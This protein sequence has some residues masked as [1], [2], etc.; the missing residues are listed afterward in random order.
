M[1]HIHQLSP[2]GCKSLLKQLGLSTQGTNKERCER[3]L[4]LSY[5]KKYNPNNKLEGPKT[6]TDIKKS[7]PNKKKKTKS[8]QDIISQ[9]MQQGN[10]VV[11]IESNTMVD[12]KKSRKE[13]NK[14]KNRMLDVNVLESTTCEKI[15]EL[16]EETSKMNI[17]DDYD[18]WSDFDAHSITFHA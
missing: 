5:S 14:E 16:N 2:D 7:K 11:S 4:H 12:R 18:D 9:L 6:L 15:N 3:L 17:E 8:A 1:K 10:Y 13:K